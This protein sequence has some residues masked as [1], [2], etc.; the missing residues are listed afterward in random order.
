M[1][2]QLNAKS[3]L[4]VDS[5]DK[6]DLENKP[7]LKVVKDK[8]DVDVD[9]I[10]VKRKIHLPKNWGMTNGTA[11]WNMKSKAMT[12]VKRLDKAKTLSEK[13]FALEQYKNSY[14]SFLESKVGSQQEVNKQVLKIV[15]S[16]VLDVSVK[17]GVTEETLN[18][19]MAHFTGEV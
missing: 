2:D 4:N 5:A 18:N 1:S 7:R 19:L 16:F 11:N 15:S 8:D 17:N 3:N 14:E 13:I 6:A 12:L 10:L 9:D